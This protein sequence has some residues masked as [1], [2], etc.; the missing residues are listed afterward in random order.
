MLYGE[1]MPRKI[2]HHDLNRAN[3]KPSNLRI[4][5]ESEQR[6]NAKLRKDNAFGER[7]V[8]LHKA[9][10]KYTAEVRCRSHRYVKYFSTA[11]EAIA[12]V[13][14]ERL[15]VFGQFAPSYDQQGT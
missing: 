8:Y 4:A 7:G 12:A 15:R 2:D 6:S 1:W 11:S 13:K 3:N 10:G 14:A 5:D 9:S